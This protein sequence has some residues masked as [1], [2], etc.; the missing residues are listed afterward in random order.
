AA[1]LLMYGSALGAGVCWVGACAANAAIARVVDAAAA[2]SSFR[3][4]ELC[5][6]RTT[7]SSADAEGRASCFACSVAAADAGERRVRLHGGGAREP[8]LATRG[9]PDDELVSAERH[10]TVRERRVAQLEVVQ[11]DLRGFGC[12]HA[13]R[14]LRWRDGDGEPLPRRQLHA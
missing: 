1:G 13:D 6:R 5:T 7:Q 12:S 8:P 10:R 4:R 11:P 9:T 2:M 3:M 14:G